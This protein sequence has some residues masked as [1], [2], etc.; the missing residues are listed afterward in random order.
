[1]QVDYLELTSACRYARSVIYLRGVGVMYREEA[2]DESEC[3]K[4]QEALDQAGAA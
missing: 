3:Q 4:E 1:M 2:I